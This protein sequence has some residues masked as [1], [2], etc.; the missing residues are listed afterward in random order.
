MS[1]NTLLFECVGMKN[2]D[3]FP[4]K[5]TGRGQDVSPEFLITAIPIRIK[6]IRPPETRQQYQKE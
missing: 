2:G 5:N 3:K 4:I 1:T 6:S